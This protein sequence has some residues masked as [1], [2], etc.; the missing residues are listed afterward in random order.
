MRACLCALVYFHFVL[1]AFCSADT[2][3]TPWSRSGSGTSRNSGSGEYRGRQEA[4][5]HE[6]TGK[7]A[8]GMSIIHAL[9][10]CPIYLHPLSRPS[11]ALR[12]PNLP[13]SSRA[14]LLFRVIISWCATKTTRMLDIA[15]RHAPGC[16]YVVFSEFSKRA[17]RLTDTHAD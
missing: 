3:L 2:Q 17:P 5:P 13:Y 4:S 12:Q 8:G 10:Y 16:Y 6:Q 15:R 7:S 1:K 14:Y 9:P 11:L